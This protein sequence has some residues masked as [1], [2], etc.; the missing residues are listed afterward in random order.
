MVALAFSFL[1]RQPARRIAVHW[2][3]AGGLLLLAVLYTLPS[4]SVV[5]MVQLPPGPDWQAVAEP[6]YPL[7]GPAIGAVPPEKD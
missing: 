6:T 5:H 7:L 1:L 3:T 2:A 4:W